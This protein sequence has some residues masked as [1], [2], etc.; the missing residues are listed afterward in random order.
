MTTIIKIYADWCMYCNM[1]A[2]EWNKMKELLENKKNKPNILEIESQNIELLDIFNK[3]NKGTNVKLNKYPTIAKY[4][5]G[6]VQYY[7][8]ERK[9]NKM[10]KWALKKTSKYTKKKQKNKRINKTSKIELRNIFIKLNI[11]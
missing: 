3:N 7:T 10:M 8:D 6:K 1:M 4:E 2:P 11:F 5:N 9:A